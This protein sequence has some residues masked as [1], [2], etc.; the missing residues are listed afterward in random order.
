MQGNELRF[1]RK[2]TLNKPPIAVRTA[3]TKLRAHA[4]LSN[5]NFGKYYEEMFEKYP[6]MEEDYLRPEIDRLFQP[7][8]VHAGGDCSKCSASML[9]ERHAR[10][11]TGPVVH[12]G[13]IGCANQVMRDALMRDQLFRQE[14][15]ICFEMEAAGLMDINCL[16]IRGICGKLQDVVFHTNV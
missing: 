8:Y 16:V 6:L 4:R 14:G 7:D 11:I 13:N 9:I 1:V 10:K 3:I 15:L 2:G 5:Y 12:Y